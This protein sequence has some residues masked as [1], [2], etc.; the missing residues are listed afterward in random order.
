MVA[1]ILKALLVFEIAVAIVAGWW[2]HDP[3]GG[4]WPAPLAVLGGL[5]AGVVPHASLLAL[6]FLIAARLRSPLPAALSDQRRP[7]PLV[8]LRELADSIRTF[9]LRQAFLA[10]RPLASAEAPGREGLLP[11]LFVHG[12]F[13]NRALWRPFAEYLAGRGHVVGSVDL[14]PVYGSIDGYADR[15]EDGIR[16]LCERT[17]HDQVALVCHSMGGLAARA[18]LRA[19]GDLA[20]ARVVTLGTPHRGTRLASLAIGRNARQMRFDSG[21]LTELAASET[22]ERRRLFTIVLSHD[23]NIVAPQALQS[24]PEAEVIER[25]GVGHI[26]L[27]LDPRVFEQVAARLGSTPG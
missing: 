16:E 20:V 12:Y 14:E 11:V 27:A 9:E 18:Y 26:S 7:L 23:D 1:L 17:G 6:E 5:A 8:W 3:L 2:L 4:D 19:H 25:A 10:G 15:I 24:L 22:P 21:W 13:C